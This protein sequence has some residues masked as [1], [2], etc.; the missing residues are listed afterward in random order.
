MKAY[1]YISKFFKEYGVTHVFYQEAILRVLMREIENGKDPAT[2]FILAHSEQAAGYM[3]DGYARA[4]GKVGVT[5]CQSIGAGNM[6][7]AIYDAYLANTPLVAITGKKTPVYQYKNCYQETDHRLLYEAVTKFNAEMLEG[8][9][10]PFLLRNAFQSATTGKARPTHLDFPD[11]QGHVA[12]MAEVEDT[13]LEPRFG[14]YPAYRPAAAEADIAAAVQ[15]IKESKKPVIVA[16]RGATASGAADELRAFAEKIDAPVV[17]TPD[18]KCLLDETDP[19]WS[20]IVG[21][22]GMDCANRTVA[23]ADLVIFV[24]TQA[25]DQTTLDWTCPRPSVRTIQIDIDGSELGKNYTNCVG[26]LG[27]ARTV[28]AQ[29]TAASPVL[30]HAEWRKEAASFVKTTLDEYQAFMNKPSE[31]ILPAKLCDEIAKVLPDDAVVVADTG[32]SAV[33]SAIMM[34][35]KKTQK[36]FRAA[37]SLGWAYPASLG[38][39]CALPD[40]PVFCFSGD[41]ALYYHLPEMETAHRYGIKTVTI[42]NANNVLGQSASGLMVV[43]KNTPD[44]GASHFRFTRPSFAQIAND[45]GLDSIVVDKVE[46]IGPALKSAMASENSVVIEVVTE[47]FSFTPPPLKQQ[48]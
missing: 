38:V 14:H 45:F 13:G 7:G 4:S 20:G 5:M 9:Q 3:A 40:R 30:D 43:H 48:P 27:D 23:G 26:L 1:D 16:G 19:L 28:L 37:G 42:V 21:N 22:Y 33:W 24:G 46:D 18:G 8:A 29:L 15:E 44:K 17:E 31:A 41:G 32:Y 2:K 36:Y 35:L 12:E 6:V 11:H 39:K 47:P 10:V 25:A 34:R